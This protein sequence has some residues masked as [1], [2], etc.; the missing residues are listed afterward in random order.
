MSDFTDRLHAITERIRQRAH[1]IWEREGH[2]HGRDQ[3][4]WDRAEKEIVAEDAAAARPAEKAEA[5]AKPKATDTAAT[6]ESPVAAAEP[7][8]A[9]KPRSK[10]A[11][12]TGAAK[13]ARARRTSPNKTAE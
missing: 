11:A 9:S 13:P 3:E 2:P 10:P 12:K 4:H 7:A 5:P 6:A 8:A 1:A